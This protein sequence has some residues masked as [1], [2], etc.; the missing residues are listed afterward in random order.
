MAAGEQSALANP[1][2]HERL[3]QTWG[4]PRGF[5]GWF[6]HVHHTSIGKRFMVTAFVFFSL[7]GILAVLM[8]IQLARSSNHF[9]GPDR[10]NTFFTMHGSTMMFLF[11]VPMMF[12]AISVYFVP[13]MVGA[14]NIAFPRLNAYSYYLYVMGGI[15]F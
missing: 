10:Y 5:W 12:E 2:R 8:R 13:L 9:L 15:M 14:R 7:A 4:E 6:M 3:S 1:A 11:A